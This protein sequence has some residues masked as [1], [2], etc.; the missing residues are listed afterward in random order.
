[1]KGVSVSDKAPRQNLDRPKSARFEQGRLQRWLVPVVFLLILL[2]I[3][4]TVVI[5]VLAILGLTP[6][7]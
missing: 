4:M 7:T 2:G 3:L 1:M 5:T 6:G